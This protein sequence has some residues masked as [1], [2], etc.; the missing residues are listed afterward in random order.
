MRFKEFVFQLVV[1]HKKAII[2][3]FFI[4]AF[5]SFPARDLVSVNYDISDYLPKETNSTKSIEALEREFSDGIPN[6]RVLVRNVTLPEALEYKKKISDVEGVSS[7][8]WLDDFVDPAMPLENIDKGVKDTY[9]KDGNALFNVAIQK[10]ARIDALDEIREIIGKDNAMSGSA[11][12][13]AVAAVESVEEVKLIKIFSVLFVL[14]VLLLTTRSWVEPIIVLIGLGVAIIINEGSNLIFGEISFVT[15]AATGIL[16]LAV[17]LDY[18]VFLIHR[19]EEC[20]KEIDDEKAAMVM[21]L[22]KS[23]QSIMGS[24]LTTV[25]GFLALVLMSL[26]LG[27]DM[28]LALAKGVAISLITVFTFTPALIMVMYKLMDKTRHKSF[29]PDLTG[30]GKT[31]HKYAIPMLIVALLMI[32]PA[33]LAS[34]SNE[35][36]FGSSNI[37]GAGTLLGKET[38]EINKTFGEKD[39]YVLMA[40]KGKTAE[41]KEF[42]EEV[43][44][45]DRVSSVVSYVDKVGAEIPGNFLDKNILDKFESKHYS[46]MIIS[47]DVPYEGDETFDLIQDIRDK[48]NKHFGKDY[49]LAGEGVSTYDLMQ[50]AT[51]DLDK[52]NMVA[53]IAIFIVLMFTLHSLIVPCILVLCIETAIWLNLAVPYFNDHPI[54]YIAYLI[55]SSI[56]LGAT[57]DY[58]ILMTDKYRE[59]R[60][61]LSK[62]R[63][64]EKT[65]SDVTVSI[66]TSGSALTVVGLLLGNISSNQL[67]AQLG[68]FIGRGALFSLAMVMFVLPEVLYIFD[69][70]AVKETRFEFIKKYFRGKRREEQELKGAES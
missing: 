29:I 19:F 68:F 18:S 35:Y 69:R 42:S 57:V 24:G 54:F 47:V 33:F 16:Q 64:A 3:L 56:Q 61:T 45:M 28:G 62:R 23:F 17:S 55:I 70:F 4:L 50:T 14:L 2:V 22:K 59:N 40:P 37:Y 58:A 21:A 32:V 49:Y 8:T 63:A 38:N 51:S 25:I 27:P 20:H 9:Y 46:R 13:T 65:V 41:Q 44:E 48:A 34:R 43:G 30:F 39:V 31:V 1:K 36:D 10:Q 53:I 66:C 15:D 6:A 67:L 52:V 26:R 7:V 5:L 11:V 60:K 12:S